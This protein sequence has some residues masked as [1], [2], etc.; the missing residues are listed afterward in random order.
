[1][2][3]GLQYKITET[4]KLICNRLSALT[5][6]IRW[7]SL[8]RYTSL[9]LVFNCKLVLEKNRVGAKV[10]PRRYKTNKACWSPFLYT[11]SRNISARCKF[12]LIDRPRVCSGLCVARCPA[13]APT[14]AGDHCAYPLRDGQ[15][16]LTW[17]KL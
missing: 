4:V 13:Y 5:V 6:R 15:A 17:G 8:S 9:K 16:E 11:L 10:L 12:T 1:M 2:S 7:S 3:A 14:F